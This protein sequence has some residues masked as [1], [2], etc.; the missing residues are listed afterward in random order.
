MEESS[1]KII[2]GI[3]GFVSGSTTSLVIKGILLLGLALFWWRIKSAL[4]EA[5][6][7]AARRAEEEKKLIDQGGLVR[8]VDRIGGAANQAADEIEKRLN[9]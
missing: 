1:L 2:E 3:A 8:E 5:Q 7:E 4:D 9:S 6:I